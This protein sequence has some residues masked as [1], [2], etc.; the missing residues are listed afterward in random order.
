VTVED[1]ETLPGFSPTVT[2][3]LVGPDV[4]AILPLKPAEPATCRVHDPEL[5]AWITTGLG[6]H[7]R[8][9]LVT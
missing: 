8:V 4:N 5:P 3:G 2:P 9:K 7:C 1:K 6:L